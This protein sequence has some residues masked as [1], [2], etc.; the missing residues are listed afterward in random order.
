[1][2]VSRRPLELEEHPAL[3]G[4]RCLSTRPASPSGL[5]DNPGFRR[6]LSLFAV[7]RSAAPLGVNGVVRRRVAVDDVECD[8][9]Q[10]VAH[11][12]EGLAA[13]PT[14]VRVSVG[15]VMREMIWLPSVT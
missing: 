8:V 7:A 12:R 15:C 5:P 11:S 3:S 1:M 2:Q 13:V 4:G 14:P 10:S 6:E 9:S